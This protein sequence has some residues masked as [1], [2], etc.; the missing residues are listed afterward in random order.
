MTVFI[1]SS[2]FGLCVG[3][4]L[5]YRTGGEVGELIGTLK[6]TKWR[7]TQTRREFR[8]ERRKLKKLKIEWEKE[9]SKR[10]N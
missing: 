1:W 4:W 9:L 5:G 6:T 2:V 10:L 8:L 3:L 7:L